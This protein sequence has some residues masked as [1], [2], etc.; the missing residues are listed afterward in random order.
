RWGLD[1]RSRRYSKVG[2]RRSRP[3]PIG[4]RGVAPCGHA[5][6]VWI[7]SGKVMGKPGRGLCPVSARSGRS[8]SYGPYA[9][10][11]MHHDAFND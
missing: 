11:V 5:E 10:G 3:L 2:G 4:T 6:V 8:L 9:G 7:K 1:S